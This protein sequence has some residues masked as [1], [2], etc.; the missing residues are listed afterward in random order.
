L[1][2][3]PEQKRRRLLMALAEW[4]FGAA[5]LQPVVM[6]VEDLHWLDPSTLDLQQVLAQQGATARLML[7]YTA[8]PQFRAPWPLRAHHTQVTLNRLSTRNVRNLVLQVVAHNALSEETLAAVV[9]RTGGVPL[10][11]EE[12]TRAVLESG[13]QS[14]VERTIPA[15]LHD[16]LMARLQRA[17]DAVSLIRNALAELQE[18]GERLPNTWL[19]LA[20]AYDCTGAIANAL[21]TVNRTRQQWPDMRV[22]QPEILRM[23]GELQFRTGGIELAEADFRES[24][25]LAQNM[26]AKAWELRSTM[27]LGRLLASNGRRDEANLRLT[28]IYHRFTEGFDTADLKNAKALL[29]E[30][31]C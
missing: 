18:M 24:I 21:E 20:N 12:L 28:D 2:L 8:R 15:T 7:L 19:F 27:S 5:S 17:T 29:D 25:A 10:F 13:R 1:T 30:L 6:V 31:S 9:E 14:L 11:V 4:L 16:S 23:R 26:G 22:Y 3:T